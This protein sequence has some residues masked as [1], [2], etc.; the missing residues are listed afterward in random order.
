[1]KTPFVIAEAGVNHNGDPDLALKLVDAA[2]SA[3]A[4]AVKFQTFR[5]SSLATAAAKKAPYQSERLGEDGSQRDMLAKLELDEATHKRLATRC[6]ERGI[7]FMSTPFDIESVDLLVRCGVKRMKVASGELTHTQLLR[8]VARTG[9]PMIVSTGM[10]TLAEVE[11]ALGVIAGEIGGG[12]SWSHPEVHAKLRERLTLLQCTTSYPAPPETANLRAMQTMR[13]AFQLPVGYSDH[14]DGPWISCAAVGL[15]AVMI[16]KHFT[17]DRKLPGPDHAASLEVEELAA[18]VAGLK[19]AGASLGTGLKAPH[20]LEL[21]NRAV[22]RRSLIAKTAI[23]RGERFT[24]ANLGAK[25]PAT[26]VGAENVDRYLGREATR[27]Y[28]ADELIEP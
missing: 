3:G 23:R 27:D 24:D 12:K 17:L 4:D 1:M 5:A 13:D 10:A 26:G 18:Y 20:P 28:A 21:P 6:K 8:V 2:A 7:E 25:R 22:A 16:E 9:L 11:N 19:A 14:T 15:G